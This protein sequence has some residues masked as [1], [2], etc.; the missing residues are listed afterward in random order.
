MFIEIF[1]ITQPFWLPQ[2]YNIVVRLGFFLVIE[3]YFWQAAA[4]QKI[5]Q[6]YSAYV[7]LYQDVSELLLLPVL[8]QGSY[9]LAKDKWY[10][11]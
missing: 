3:Q 5:K 11:Y 8:I 6:N 10:Y 1:C 4:K 9:L 2:N 7:Q